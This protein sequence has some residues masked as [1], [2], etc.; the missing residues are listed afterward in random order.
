VYGPDGKLALKSALTDD[1][2]WLSESFGDRTPWGS[3]DHEAPVSMVESDLERQLSTD[4]MQPG[5]RPEI[6]RLPIGAV[7]TRQ[8]EPG[9]EL[10]LVLDGVVG[11]DVDGARLGEVGPGATLGER[12]ILEGGRRTSTLTAITPVRLAVVPVAAIDINRLAQLAE[13]HRRE[14]G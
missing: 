14:P 4:I 10:F 8:G 6:R 12:A 5:S 11:V 9:D 2:L 3:H 1:R 13:L 7:I